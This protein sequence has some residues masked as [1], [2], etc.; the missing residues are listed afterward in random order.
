VR[1]VLRTL[2]PGDA[3]RVVFY[4]QLRVDGQLVEIAGVDRLANRSAAIGP[5]AAH[6]HA[7]IVRGAPDR[8]PGAREA[9]PG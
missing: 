8:R 5:A 3:R 2:S 9:A 1:R 4:R 7:D 6:V